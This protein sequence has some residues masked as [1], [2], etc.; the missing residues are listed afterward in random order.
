[1][2]K[3]ALRSNRKFRRLLALVRADSPEH[4]R[5]H[6]SALWEATWEN[7]TPLV[8]DLQ[9]VEAAAGWTMADTMKYPPGAFGEA[10][11][12][13]RLLDVV[14]PG[15]LFA[16][17][18]WYEHAPAY[19]KQR[20]GRA[21]KE[22]PTVCPETYFLGLEAWQRRAAEIG[23]DPVEIAFED[24]LD[25]DTPAC[26]N[27]PA[28]YV[29][30]ANGDRNA[31]RLDIRSPKPGPRPQNGY[32]SSLAE[33]SQAETSP[34]ASPSPRSPSPSFSAVRAPKVQPVTEPV[35]DRE[36]RLAARQVTDA[37]AHLFA[38]GVRADAE[39]ADELADA[40]GDC[41]TSADWTALA[42]LANEALRDSARFLSAQAVATTNATAHG[43]TR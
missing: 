6:L 18:D 13:V 11:A 10:L 5:G 25:P 15:K 27:L 22:D 19:V 26:G 7:G 23:L 2:A 14:V 24:D 28:G 20:I 35:A 4:V 30:T 43:A 9:D 34:K 38:T 8:G 37:I 32:L 39:S 12:T 31:R 1:M 33:T 16:V 17:H 29:E 21:V 40:A 3:L 42:G 36:T 41:R